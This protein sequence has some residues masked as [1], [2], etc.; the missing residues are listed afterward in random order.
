MIRLIKVLL[1]LSVALFCLV[2]GLQNLVNLEEAYGFVALMASMADHTA[3][4]DH[5]GPAVTWA[6]L[7]WLMLGIIVALEFLAGLL[8]AKGALDMWRKRNAYAD[9]FNA[10]KKF[11]IAGAGVGVLIW[12]GIFSAIGGAYFQMWQTQAGNGALTGAFWYSMQCGVVLL[13]IALQDD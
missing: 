10:A 3:Y 13:I 11:A 5:F 12:F 1:A 8:A 2:Y 4:P 6:P 9:E 7:I